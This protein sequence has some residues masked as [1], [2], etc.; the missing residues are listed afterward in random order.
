M[1]PEGSNDKKGIG[2]TIRDWGSR[3]FIFVRRAY[4]IK[5]LIWVAAIAA[6]IFYLTVRRDSSN[7][8]MVYADRN[9]SGS[10]K[11]PLAANPS[12]VGSYSPD[13]KAGAGHFYD[14]VL[15]YRVWLHP[16]HGAS[17]RN[18]DNDYFEAFAQYEKAEEF[19]KASAGAEEPLVLIRQL[20]WIDEPEPG[21]YIAKKG[22]RI[23]EWQV[24]WLAGSKRTTA[25]IQEFMRHPKQ[26][27]E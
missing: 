9:V 7:F 26:N 14:D 4:R 8:V 5:Y 17:R 16:D 25:S 20:E 2:A 13:T 15:E 12:L 3:F 27:E 21:H 24:R 6:S 23:T 11:Y 22:E 19:S 1:S 10:S 18:G